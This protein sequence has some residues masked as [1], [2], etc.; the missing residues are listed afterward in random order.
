MAA[1]DPITAAGLRLSAL[2]SAYLFSL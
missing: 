2:K 1:D